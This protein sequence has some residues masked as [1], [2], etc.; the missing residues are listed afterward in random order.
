[1]AAV[2]ALKMLWFILIGLTPSKFEI[3]SLSSAEKSPS[4]PIITHNGLLDILSIFNFFFEVFKSVKI[5]SI[6][7]AFFF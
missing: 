2:S 1:M 5:K 4:G 7:F 3:C 6:F